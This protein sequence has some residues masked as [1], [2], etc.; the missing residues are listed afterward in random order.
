MNMVKHILRRLTWKTHF[1]NQRIK[2]KIKNPN[3]WN[4]ELVKE[5]NTIEK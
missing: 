2:N 1:M 3:Q 4:K 5:E